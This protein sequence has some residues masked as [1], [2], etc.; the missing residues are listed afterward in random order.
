MRARERVSLHMA[1]LHLAQADGKALRAIG[2]LEIGEAGAIEM[3]AELHRLRA[4]ELEG[5]AWKLGERV[6]AEAEDSRG[7]PKPSIGTV[8]EWAT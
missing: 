3:L 2:L 7:V 6:E 1:R 4:E 8:Q 5:M